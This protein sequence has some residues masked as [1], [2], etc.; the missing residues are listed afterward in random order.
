MQFVT[1]YSRKSLR[2]LGSV[3]EP[4]NPSA[5]RYTH[6]LIPNYCACQQHLSWA[7][8]N[9]VCIHHRWFFNVVGESRC[10]IS[11]TWWQ[12]ETGGFMVWL[13]LLISYSLSLSNI[14]YLLF[15]ALPGLLTF[16]ILAYFRLLLY[17]VLGHR[18]LVRPHFHSLESRYSDC[19]NSFFFLSIMKVDDERLH[20]SWLWCRLL[21]FFFVFSPA[22]C[23]SLCNISY[24][25]SQPVIVDEKGNEIEGECSGYL[26]IKNSWPGA[27]RTLYGD[28]ERYETTY[29]KPFAGYYFTGDGCSR[30]CSKFLILRHQCLRSML[31]LHPGCLWSFF[32]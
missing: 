24:G 9:M 30:Y 1:H 32:L 6:S 26:C 11:D 23:F 2:V 21:L 5:W 18:S 16:M 27:F 14:H 22:S 3:G 12:T 28:H 29:F 20:S 15:S 10:P 17:L 19:Q 4:I 25:I 7:T 13:I 8:C 31:N